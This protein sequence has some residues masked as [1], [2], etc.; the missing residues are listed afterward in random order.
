[1]LTGSLF[2]SEL[3]GYEYLTQLFKIYFKINWDIRKLEVEPV[4][5]EVVSK[6]YQL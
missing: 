3:I 6:C 2:L 1:M 5:L 4:T